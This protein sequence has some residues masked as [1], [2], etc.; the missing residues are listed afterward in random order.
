MNHSFPN[1]M[2]LMF[3][4][5]SKHASSGKFQMCFVLTVKV[6]VHTV[7]HVCPCDIVW[8][9]LNGELIVFLILFY[10]N[11]LPCKY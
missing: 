7:I 11:I 6:V 4:F 1:N 9:F 2:L 10:T 5:D 3:K 8:T